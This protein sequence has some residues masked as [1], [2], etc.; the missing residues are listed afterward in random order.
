MV[1]AMIQNDKHFWDT[2]RMKVGMDPKRI[3]FSHHEWTKMRKDAR[4]AIHLHPP[5]E[6]T[7]DQKEIS[8]FVKNTS[9]KMIYNW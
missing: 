5:L 4:Q 7:T 2:F 1:K 9:A 6:S 8:S 3:A